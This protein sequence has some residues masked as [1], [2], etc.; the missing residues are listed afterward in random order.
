MTEHRQPFKE[1]LSKAGDE[2]LRPDEWVV[3]P[4]YEII[5]VED[6]KYVHAPMTA[7]QF[8]GRELYE[9]LSHQWAH[10]FLEFAEW[11]EKLG[12][13][14]K[15]PEAKENEEAAQAWARRYGVLGV[16]PPDVTEW[17]YSSSAIE[18]YLGRPGPDG[19]IGKRKSN[20]GRGGYPNESVVRFTDE[21]FEARF[22]FRLY[23][24]AIAEPAPDAKTII[25]LM[26]KKPD[27]WDKRLSLSSIEGLHG[28]S[29]EAARN[30]ALQ[31]VEE[32]VTRK[33]A[34][35]CYP[36]LLGSGPGSYEQGWGFESLL[37]AMWMQMLWFLTGQTRRCLH[38]G[39]VLSGGLSD[40]K[41]CNDDHRSA[42]HYRHADRKSNGKK[43]MK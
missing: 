17:G 5:E 30:W 9:P 18:D 6:R 20:E 38:C 32:A 2:W 8:E 35:R 42:W 43:G 41:Y 34:G 29:P 21:A 4:D 31:V 25:A 40:K 28:R 1:G 33:V 22:V 13:S 36:A 7:E 14:R 3:Y 23:D 37:G 24:A 39:E 19:S 10:L 26:G 27:G 11:A 16:N 12:M 15:L